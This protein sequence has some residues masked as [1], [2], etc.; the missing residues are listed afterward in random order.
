[1]SLVT[2][3]R[4]ER[5][6]EKIEILEQMIENQTRDLYQAKER[7]SRLVDTV[8]GA[9]FRCDQS[10]RITMVNQS[11]ASL[12]GFE[13]AE[14]EGRHFDDLTS[15]EILGQKY[16]LLSETLDQIDTTL[17]HRS[18]DSIPVLLSSNV[19][20][21]REGRLE[22]AVCIAIDMRKRSELEREY[23]QKQ[24]LES[25]GQ[26]AAGIAHEINSPIQF[27]GDS[28]QFLSEA[29][30]DL[31][32]AFD[33]SSALRDAAAN[34]ETLRA[35][36]EKYDQACESA[37]LEFLAEEIPGAILRTVDGVARVSKIVSAMKIFSH[38]GG[39]EKAPAD[40]NKAIET[41]LVIAANETKY[42]ADVEVDLNQIPEVHC[43]IGDINQVILNL[44]VNAAHAIE[45]FRAGDRGTI[46]IRT[47][48]QNEHVLI[49]ISDNGGGVPDEIRDRIFD[50]FF[51]TK[52][53]GKGTGQGLG[54]ARKVIVDGHG[55]DLRIESKAGEGATFAIE[56]P[57]GAHRA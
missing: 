44:V 18:G 23:H 49:E 17:I 52:E 15:L 8:R 7:L 37:D 6:N 20:H 54:I 22:G 24:K 32:Q 10:G 3:K 12:L 25:I 51:T 57:I 4:L 48:T 28:A 47:S 46:H 53:V 19:L 43:K 5:A 40:L 30:E 29:W 39:E 45:S 56:L 26:L 14:L 41:T 34:D 1:M 38:P 13:A 9:I 35:V 42:V 27:V 55:G 16:D 33:A 2:E 11:A 36:V 31:A 50:P 21:D